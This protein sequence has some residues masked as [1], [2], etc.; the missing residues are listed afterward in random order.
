MLRS[1]HKHFVSRRNEIPKVVHEAPGSLVLKS[2]RFTRFEYNRFKISLRYTDFRVLFSAHDAKVPAMFY[3]LRERRPAQAA[4]E[5]LTER[6]PSILCYMRQD[7]RW[8]DW[9]CSGIVTCCSLRVKLTGG[10]SM[11]LRKNIMYAASA[12]VRIKLWKLW[13]SIT[14]HPLCILLAPYARRDFWT[15]SSISR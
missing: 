6:I 8:H 9:I 14:R 11:T 15:M 3:I 5:D 10:I 13:R 7:I 1:R 12:T 2:S 4:H